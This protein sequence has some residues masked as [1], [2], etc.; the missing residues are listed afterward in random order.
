MTIKTFPFGNVFIYDSIK[1][2]YLFG[3]SASP[4]ENLLLRTAEMSVAIPLNIRLAIIISITSS[5]PC[6]SLFRGSERIAGARKKDCGAR[7]FD[8][9]NEIV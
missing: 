8:G 4:Q 1:F 3:F 7:K 5:S 6:H 9:Q 2:R